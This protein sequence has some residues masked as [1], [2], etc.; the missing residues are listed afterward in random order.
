MILRLYI[1]FANELAFLRENIWYW[2]IVLKHLA[3]L[4]FPLCTTQIKNDR[5]K[6]ISG[7]FCTAL[8]IYPNLLFYVSIDTK[9]YNNIKYLTAFRK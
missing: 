2:L 8:S 9:R 6:K 5:M 3:E 7:G 4:F 1:I